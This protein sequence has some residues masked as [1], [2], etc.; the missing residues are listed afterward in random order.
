MVKWKSLISK[1]YRVHIR[2]SVMS[3]GGKR[4]KRVKSKVTS[5][6]KKT[7][8][9]ALLGDKLLQAFQEQDLSELESFEQYSHELRARIQFTPT[10]TKSFTRGYDLLRKRV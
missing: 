7:N 6:R 5:K 2:G 4:Q 10:F 8:S 1:N 9:L 3:K